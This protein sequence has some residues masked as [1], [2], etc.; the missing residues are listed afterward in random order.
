MG[1]VILLI[2][3][4]SAKEKSDNTEQLRLVETS[5]EG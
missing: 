1:R 3:L 2:C 4:Y 5:Q